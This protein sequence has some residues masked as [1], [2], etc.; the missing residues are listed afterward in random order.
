MVNTLKTPLLIGGPSVTLVLAL[1]CLSFGEGLPRQLSDTTNKLQLKIPK[2]QLQPKQAKALQSKILKKAL[3]SKGQ[4]DELQKEFKAQYSNAT[5][6]EEE[7][8]L[9]L[10]YANALTKA[11]MEKGEQSYF[12]EASNVFEKVMETGATARQQ[13]AARN[14]YATI[15]LKSGNKKK[16][17]EILEAGYNEKALQAVDGAG[18]A[19]YLFNFASVL[20]KGNQSE[21]SIKSY[22][23]AYTAD[24]RYIRAANSALRVAL[25]SDS[26]PAISKVLQQLIQYGQLSVAE[27]NFRILFDQPKQT[28]SDEFVSIIEAFYEYLVAAQVG[29][30]IFQVEW[31]SYLDSKKKGLSP[32][33]KT[34]MNFV[35]RAYDSTLPIRIK[36]SRSRKYVKPSRFLAN[37]GELYAKRGELSQALARYTSAWSLDN[38]NLSAGQYAANLLIEYPDKLDPE[39]KVLRD[40]TSELFSGKGTAYLGEDWPNIFRFHILLGSIY[41]KKEEWGDSFYPFGARFQLEHALQ[42]RKKIPESENEFKEA[43]GLYSMLG[44]TFVGLGQESD[45]FKNYVLA[46]NDALALGDKELG[47]EMLERVKA[48][49][50]QPTPQEKQKLSEIKTRL[51]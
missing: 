25:A 51:L 33:S 24:P 42:A 2:T 7:T 11:Y 20:E 27:T 14:N 29:P 13:L 6:T 1:T 5:S 18:R 23:E 44:Q 26:L 34:L 50:Y 39:G 35:Y 45:A 3:V 30:T 21:K 48:L 36:K 10:S 40:L 16:A 9:S 41:V 32:K 49:N 38:L 47:N 37:V 31:R 22:L 43:P 15:A 46:A 19:R 17:L 8:S 12:Q 4:I 28:G